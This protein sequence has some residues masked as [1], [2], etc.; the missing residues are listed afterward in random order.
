M[1]VTLSTVYITGHKYNM[2]LYFG[3]QLA[4]F[5]NVNTASYCSDIL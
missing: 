5:D 2:P 4:L 3:Q 1:H